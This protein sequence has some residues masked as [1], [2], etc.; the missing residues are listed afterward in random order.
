[1]SDVN[2]GTQTNF[3]DYQF[4][5]STEEVAKINTKL[6]KPGIYNG[7][8]LTIDSGDDIL[9]SPLIALCETSTG[10]V[11]RITTAQNATLTLDSTTPYAILS[12]TW[13]NS[14]NWYAD[15]TAKA[16]GDITTIDVILGM[17]TY[18]GPTLTSFDYSSKTWGLFDSNYILLAKDGLEIPTAAP[19]TL[20]A[21]SMY[22]DTATSRLYCYDG[23][24]WKYS[25][26]S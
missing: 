21:G 20:R 2:N 14:L 8:T 5:A 16:V 18:V 15:F 10:Q 6:L 24:T 19:S 9:I 26:L 25:T 22:F 11:I 3:L 7:G 1:M 4:E 17:G 13:D 23:S 12:Y